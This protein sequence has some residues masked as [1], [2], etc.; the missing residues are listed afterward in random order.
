MMQTKMLYNNNY[1]IVLER[2]F[3][4]TKMVIDIEWKYYI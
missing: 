1:P 3:S 2:K 4:E